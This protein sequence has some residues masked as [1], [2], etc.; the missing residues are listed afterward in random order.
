M[1]REEDGAKVGEGRFVVRVKH[2]GF[3]QGG[4]SALVSAN[5]TSLPGLAKVR[6]AQISEADI[7]PWVP[8]DPAC[9][10]TIKSSV[11]W[12]PGSGIESSRPRETRLEAR[13]SVTPLLAKRYDPA[14]IARDTMNSRII[15]RWLM[16]SIPRAWM[17]Q[18]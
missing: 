3:L 5:V 16:F 17:T 2:Q 14:T 13:E 4:F 9:Q 10:K 11:V 15:L 6:L 7:V 1:L 8:F 12:T 18:E